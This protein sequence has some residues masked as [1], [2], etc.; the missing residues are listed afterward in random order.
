MRQTRRQKN[1]SSEAP[2]TLRAAAVKT[3]GGGFVPLQFC[4]RWRDAAEPSAVAAFLGAA[5]RGVRGG[6]RRPTC[7]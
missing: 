2:A 5:L 4:L 7:D 1:G 3:T 6:K